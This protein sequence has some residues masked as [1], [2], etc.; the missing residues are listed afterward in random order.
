MKNYYNEIAKPILTMGRRGVVKQM[1][2]AS[3]RVSD[4]NTNATVMTYLKF[5]FGNFVT[6]CAV[7][8]SQTVK[9]KILI[10]KVKILILKAIS[11][12]QWRGCTYSVINGIV[13][14]KYVI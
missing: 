13:E 6:A 12:F 5:T 2:V 3:G 1:S 8:K 10:L 11:Q 9:L 7:F 4:N 14:F